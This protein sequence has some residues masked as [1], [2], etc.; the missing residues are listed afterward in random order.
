MGG[1][2]K[3]PKESDEQRKSREEQEKLMEQQRKSAEQQSLLKIP[4]IKPLKPPAPPA[5][6]SSADV[7]AAE[8]DAKRSAAKRTNTARGTL[9]A[10]ET[11]GYGNKLG[12]A[13]TLL[14]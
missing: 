2:P 11:G 3:A 12:G 1:S 5:T 7:A 4:T 9:F 14:G 8:E 6:E 10:G 13:K